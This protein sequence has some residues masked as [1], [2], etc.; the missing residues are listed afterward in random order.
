MCTCERAHFFGELPCLFTF[1][2]QG[3]HRHGE[4]QPVRHKYILRIFFRKCESLRDTVP[5]LIEPPRKAEAQTGGAKN[6]YE[7]VLTQ[8]SRGRPVSLRVIVPKDLL[9]M[10]LGTRMS[11]PEYLARRQLCMELNQQQRI[12][13]ALGQLLFLSYHLFQCWAIGAKQLQSS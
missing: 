7:W 11:P 8:E 3:L 12:M 9:I 5:A 1:A 6:S 10:F 2:A 4:Q 13:K